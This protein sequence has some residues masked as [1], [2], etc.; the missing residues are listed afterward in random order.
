MVDAQQRE[1]RGVQVVA[2]DSEGNDHRAENGN[3]LI[4]N[5]PMAFVLPAGHVAK[6]KDFEL[7]FDAPGNDLN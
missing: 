1:H 6:V 7:S 4:L 3:I 5:M 2:K